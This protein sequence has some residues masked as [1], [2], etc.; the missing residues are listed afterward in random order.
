VVLLAYL[1]LNTTLNITRNYPLILE[2]TTVNKMHFISQVTGLE[3][4]CNDAYMA[5]NTALYSILGQALELEDEQSKRIEELEDQTE[6]TAEL[7]GEMAALQGFFEECFNSLEVYYPCPSYSNDYDKSVI[8]EAI[9]LGEE[10]RKEQEQE[11]KGN[12]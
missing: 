7:Q 11:S 6:F 3:Q 2:Q 9:Q 10:Y 4:A 12:K 5:G 8:F 1:L